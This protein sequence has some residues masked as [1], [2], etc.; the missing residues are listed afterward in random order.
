MKPEK[1]CPHSFG[2][3]TKI[4]KLEQKLE[5]KIDNNYKTLNIKFMAF[6]KKVYKIVKIFIGFCIVCILTLFTIQYITDTQ[7]NLLYYNLEKKVVRMD[8]GLSSRDMDYFNSVSEI[9]YYL[10]QINKKLNK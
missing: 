10:E 1:I 7:R 8:S 9:Q 4:N 3:D 5:Q 2:F 6:E